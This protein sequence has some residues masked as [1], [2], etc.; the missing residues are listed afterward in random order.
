M[1]LLYS[2]STPLHKPP[3]SITYLP[4]TTNTVF[5]IFSLLSP[6]LITQNSTGPAHMLMVWGHP[7]EHD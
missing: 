7:L 5:C 3:R 4:I 6:H 2:S 1:F